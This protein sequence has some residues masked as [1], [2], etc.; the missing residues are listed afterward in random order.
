[1]GC[2]AGISGTPMLLSCKQNPGTEQCTATSKLTAT[3]QLK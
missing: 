1:M 2:A 3:F